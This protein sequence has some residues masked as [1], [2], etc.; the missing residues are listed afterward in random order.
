MKKLVASLVTAVSTAS[1]MVAPITAAPLAHAC[2][3]IGSGSNTVVSSA[4]PWDVCNVCSGQTCTNGNGVWA[5]AIV[6]DRCFVSPGV[7]L[8]R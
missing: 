4:G 7:I 8:C 6:G 1:A 2:T 3:V 5:P